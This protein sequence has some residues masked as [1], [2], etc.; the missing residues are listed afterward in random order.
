MVKRVVVV[1]DISQRK[2]FFG[3]VFF[4]G[5]IFE[6][7]FHNDTNKV[8]QTFVTIVVGVLLGATRGANPF[9]RALPGRYNTVE[10]SRIC[11][12]ISSRNKRRK[13][14]DGVNLELCN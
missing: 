5:A 8:D 4:F 9:R 11:S 6:I 13:V 1:I 3:S 7:S 14:Q 12:E 2:V 10:D